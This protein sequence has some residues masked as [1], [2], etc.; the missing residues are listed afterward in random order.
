MGEQNLLCDKQ[1]PVVD[2]IKDVFIVFLPVMV[3]Q[4]QHFMTGLN[5]SGKLPASDIP[6]TDKGII[7]FYQ[8][9]DDTD[10]FFRRDPVRIHQF[11][12]TVCKMSI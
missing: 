9:V 11:A 2:L 3:A 1:W 4:Y 8:T 7:L 6:K 10:L 12:V 5:L